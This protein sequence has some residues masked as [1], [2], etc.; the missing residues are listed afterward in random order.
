[1][2]NIHMINVKLNLFDDAGAPMWR[3]N[4]HKSNSTNERLADGLCNERYGR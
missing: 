1:M 4:L 3:L 2:Y